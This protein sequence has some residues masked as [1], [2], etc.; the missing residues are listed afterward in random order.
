LLVTKNLLKCY[1]DSSTVSDVVNR[2]KVYQEE[3]V[4]GIKQW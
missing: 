1:Y 4:D 2:Q 3:C